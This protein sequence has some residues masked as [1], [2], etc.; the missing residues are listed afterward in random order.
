MIRP[1]R[2]RLVQGCEVFPR[3]VLRF[4]ASSPGSRVQGLGASREGL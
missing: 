3:K 4:G 1:T 2:K